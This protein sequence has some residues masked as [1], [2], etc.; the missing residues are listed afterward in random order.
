MS[1][2]LKYVDAAELA[3]ILKSDGESVA[4][5]DVRDEAEFSGGHIKGAF[6]HPSVNWSDAE[7]VESVAEKV[8]FD[9][10]PKKIV[11]HCVHSQKR[12]PTCARILQTRLEELAANGTDASV[13][14][15]V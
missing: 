1:T 13:L 9:G 10:H 6:N 5:L 3:E 11:M 14:P 12:G 8:T 4:I 15:S 7:F 2:D